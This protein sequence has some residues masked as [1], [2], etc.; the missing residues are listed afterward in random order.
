MA[1][2]LERPVDRERAV[3]GTLCPTAWRSQY[4]FAEKLM[5]VSYVRLVSSGL[6]DL[7]PERA[8]SVLRLET[9]V[10]EQ[11]ADEDLVMRSRELESTLVLLDR[12][13]VRGPNS[14]RAEGR[15]ADRSASDRSEVQTVSSSQRDVRRTVVEGSRG[16]F[17]PPTSLLIVRTGAF[18]LPSQE[19]E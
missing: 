8:T 18:S 13:R 9:C 5:D 12:S 2:R 16:P 17:G 14:L 19:D 6:L 15:V 3:R 4:P 1:D 11:Q 7:Q 10:S